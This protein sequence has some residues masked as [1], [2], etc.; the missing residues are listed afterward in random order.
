MLETWI[1]INFYIFNRYLRS[2]F[3][4]KNRHWSDCGANKATVPKNRK[5]APIF[6]TTLPQLLRQQV[7]PLRFGVIGSNIETR[8]SHDRSELSLPDQ[9]SESFVVENGQAAGTAARVV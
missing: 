3:H 1:P 9:M 6:A 8:D 5:T 2:K 7:Q 4:V